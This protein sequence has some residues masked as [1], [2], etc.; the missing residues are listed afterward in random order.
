MSQIQFR[1]VIE[2]FICEYCHYNVTGNG[3]TNHCPNCLVSKHVD[4]HPGDRAADCDGMMVVVKIEYADSTWI[5]THR[6]KICGHEKRNRIEANDN[7]ERLAEL[8]QELN[9]I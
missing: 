4:V 7:L 6:C 2:N 3:Y 9:A 5:L 8:Q 1:K